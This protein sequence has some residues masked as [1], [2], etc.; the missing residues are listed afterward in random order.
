MSVVHGA[1]GQ[2]G[3]RESQGNGWDL[4]LGLD[5]NQHGRSSSSTDVDMSLEEEKGSMGAIRAGQLAC[6]SPG[7]T[8]VAS[9]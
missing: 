6:P 4:D 1:P 9:A 3:Q 7:L 2:S 8:F 5:W